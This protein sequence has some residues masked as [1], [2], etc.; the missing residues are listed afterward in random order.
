MKPLILICILLNSIFSYCQ[1]GIFIIRDLV[2][3]EKDTLKFGFHPLATIGIDSILGERDISINNLKNLDFRIIQ[4]SA[5]NFYCLF[6]YGARIENG[7]FVY[8]SI[9]YKPAFDSKINYRSRDSVNRYFEILMHYKN[10]V[11][12]S[13]DFGIRFKYFLDKI[14]YYVRGCPES[15]PIVSFGSDP[16]IAE[17]DAVIFNTNGPD[18]HMIWVFKDSINISV[19]SEQEIEETE[20]VV[21]PTPFSSSFNIQT[22]GHFNFL[23][24]VD[25]SGKSYFSIKSLTGFNIFHINSNDWPNGMYM[26]KALTKSGHKIYVKKLIKIQG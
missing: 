3:N 16:V 1:N 19:N 20:I 24:V 18:Y 17:A 11:H 5:E 23:E 9:F 10:N 26:L 21:Y 13:V 2:T 7:A 22:E 25:L 4:R 12:I 8:D 15:N 6:P 14:I